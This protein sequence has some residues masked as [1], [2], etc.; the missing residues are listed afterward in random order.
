MSQA[1]FDEDGTGK[2]E[3]EQE[4]IAVLEEDDDD[5]DGGDATDTDTDADDDDD[6]DA[7]EKRLG[8]G[9]DEEEDEDD[10]TKRERRR[11]ENRTRRRRQRAARER[12]ER[13]LNF[14]RT[15]NEQLERRFSQLETNLAAR[16]TSSDIARLDEAITKRKSDLQL[17]NNVMQ[18]ALE[19]NNAKNFT[20]ALEHRDAIRDEVHE[21]EAT[22]TYL[23]EEDRDAGGEGGEGGGE[24]RELDP[25]QLAHAQ[26]FM[27]DHDWWNPR[28]QGE[29][30]MRVRQIDA[31]VLR[32][33]YDPTTKDYWDELRTRIK[34]A[35]PHRFEDAGDD[36]DSDDDDDRGN[37]RQRQ[38]RKGAGS[39][40][41][42]FRTGGRERPLK[43]NEV[44]IT[45][46]R[47]EAME[48]AGVWDDP[49]TRKKYLKAYAEYDEEAAE[50]E[51][52]A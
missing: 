36:D 14:L 46:E 22:R 28:G 47:R 49:V 8:G 4:L 50:A 2:E 40:G 12:T 19:N 45:K 42:Q 16:V 18:Q 7:K 31:T 32:E 11:E 27:Q 1:E 10:E 21:L 33:G 26:S 24:R 20:E 39:G 23:S 29:D 43:K 44:Y 34:E 5:S 6:E 41:P 38:R 51:R 9:R 35:L 48:E 37:G 52:R 3:D 17:A 25:R 15:R 30:D 13:E